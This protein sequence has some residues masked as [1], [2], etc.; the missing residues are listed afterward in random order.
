ME[1]AEI[2]SEYR[3]NRYFKGDDKYDYIRY[4]KIGENVP[5]FNRES[6]SGF[7][8]LENNNENIEYIKSISRDNKIKNL[9]K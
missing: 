7:L 2:I 4:F 6:I 9:I 3:N 1:T 8:I 5:S